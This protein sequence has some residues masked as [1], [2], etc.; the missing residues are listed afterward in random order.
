MSR[1][2]VPH[3]TRMDEDPEL[4]INPVTGRSI[5]YGLRPHRCDDRLSDIIAT[6]AAFDYPSNMFESVSRLVRCLRSEPGAEPDDDYFNLAR[7]EVM[8]YVERHRCGMVRTGVFEKYPYDRTLVASVQ[9]EDST[10]MRV[11]R[12]QREMEVQAKQ[13]AVDD[14]VSSNVTQNMGRR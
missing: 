14:I 10:R 7:R 12:H 2:P 6:V 13:G 5:Y 1:M 11:W 3:Y 8:Y 9:Q 4:C